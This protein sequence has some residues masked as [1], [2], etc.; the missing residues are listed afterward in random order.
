LTQNYYILTMLPG[1]DQLGDAPPISGPE[2][3]DQLEPGSAPRKLARVLLLSDDL[4]QRDAA[5]AGE[6][7][8][9]KPSVLTREQA[10]GE[11]PLPE[12]LQSAAAGDATTAG[13][14]VPGDA[15]WEAYFRHAAEV[16]RETRSTFLAEWVAWEVGLRN[17]LVE[18]RARELNIE[19]GEFMVAADLAATA[20]YEDIVRDWAQ[21][22]N[23]LAGQR[24]LD[25]A[26]WEWMD[27]NDAYFSFGD[28]ELA[29]YVARLILTQRWF[30]LQQEIDKETNP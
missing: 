7:D 9:P 3:L 14:R 22:P 30:R 12:F 10:L 29:A 26:R 6:V 28:D 20:D 25:T 4:L 8:E 1:L 16:A 11:A 21:A 19:P 18:A 17:A 2:L 13:P 5:L 23:P 24:V 15:L 27:M